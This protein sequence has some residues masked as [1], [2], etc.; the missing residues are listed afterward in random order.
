MSVS[1]ISWRT[2]PEPRTA[3]DRLLPAPP[4]QRPPATNSRSAF[5]RR[6][7]V[8]QRVERRD[9]L[10]RASQSV[11]HVRHGIAGRGPTPRRIRRHSQRE[12]VDRRQ[13][14]LADGTIVLK[15]SG[16]V[17]NAADLAMAHVT[18][19]RRQRHH[20]RRH[21]CHAARDHRL[22]PARHAHGHPLARCSPHAATG[23]TLAC[24]SLRA[25]AA[26]TAADRAQ[27]VYL[28]LVKHLSASLFCFHGR[29]V[30]FGGN[31]TAAWLR[32]PSRA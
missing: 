31:W 2:H 30:P 1:S 29:A 21:R 28:A 5:L 16:T 7:R 14:D 19:A 9:R 25:A 20:T 3:P 17:G 8:R 11:E 15:T 12:R 4:Q 23:R 32:S 6:F 24:R 18:F 27:F 26:I 22:K 10:H 13:N